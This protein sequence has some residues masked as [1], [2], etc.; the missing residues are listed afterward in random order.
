[1]LGECSADGGNREVDL[2]IGLLLGLFIKFLIG[3]PNAY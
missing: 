3:K 2:E 1:M